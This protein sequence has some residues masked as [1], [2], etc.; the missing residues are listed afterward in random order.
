MFLCRKEELGRL[1]ELYDSGHPQ[2][3]VIYGRRRVGKTALINEFIKD[4][5]AIYF[6]ALN[7][8]ARDNL[9]ALSRSVQEHLIPGVRNV[10]VYPSFDAAFDAVTE[11][12]RRERV[13]FVIDDLRFLVKAAPSVID[14][15]R[16]H[17]SGKWKQTGVFLIL[18]GSSAGYMEK[19]I[20]EGRHSLSDCVTGAI[21]LEPLDYLD[22]AGFSPGLAPSD[23]AIVYA[24]T[25]GI[26][27]Y[28]NKLGAGK[29]VRNA[30]INNL[31][32]SSSYLFEEPENYLKTE[33]RE[34]AVYNSILTAIANGY[35]RLGDIA[36]ETGM[37]SAACSKYITTLTDLGILHKVEPVIG[38]SKR[39]TQYRI[40][41]NLFRFWY[42]FVPANMMK[43]SSGRPAGVY[44]EEVKESLDDYMA[45]PF[46]DI[47]RQYLIRH[48][49]ELGADITEMGEWWDS[50][51][52]HL[53][54]VAYADKSTGR[55]AGRRYIV[56][57]CRYSEEP[58]ESSELDDMRRAVAGF[59]D[60]NDECRYYIFSKSGF[61]QDLRKRAE[62]GEVSLVSIEEIYT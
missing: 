34:P 4:K 23:K 62:A 49:A 11:I 33:L 39:R 35:T 13:I 27:H 22:A 61:T 5:N 55:T 31:L 40:A 56:G 21:K 17:A 52:S 15:L 54:I 59:T 30:L 36:G 48:S 41:D 28:I 12:S 3:M 46:E 18:C 50:P 25:G 47:C 7:T 51:E 58:V 29:D 8:N 9:C 60:A 2:C 42:R 44:D 20:L 16:D 1:E 10:P 45:Q 38:R 24:V 37:E 53:D 19:E 14:S 26:P 43:I 32:D 57:S 6:P